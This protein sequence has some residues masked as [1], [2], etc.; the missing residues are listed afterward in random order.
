M[1]AR[2]CSRYQGGKVLFGKQQWVFSHMEVEGRGFPVWVVHFDAEM[3]Q[4]S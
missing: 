1:K 2:D 3:R 4:E